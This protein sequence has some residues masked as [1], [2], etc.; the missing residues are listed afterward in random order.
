MEVSE[1]AL[2]WLLN[3]AIR[4]TRREAL[5]FF[6]AKASPLRPKDLETLFKQYS[7]QGKFLA[8]QLVNRMRREG[9]LE[10][11][12]HEGRATYYKLTPLGEEVARL[13]W[14]LGL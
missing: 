10:I 3:R 12:R 4:G 8:A 11:D 9:L 2:R 1:E 14:Q 6:H 7:T 5:K 13:L